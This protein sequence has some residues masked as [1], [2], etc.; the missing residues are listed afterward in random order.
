MISQKSVADGPS[1]FDEDTPV[2]TISKGVP[3]PVRANTHSAISTDEIVS[4][5][6]AEVEVIII[7]IDDGQSLD[8]IAVRTDC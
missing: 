8:Y 6:L 3:L 5:T 7:T 2:S 1:M 4:S